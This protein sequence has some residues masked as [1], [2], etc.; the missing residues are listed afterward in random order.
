MT[1]IQQLREKRYRD[2]LKRC[3]FRSWKAANNR[4]C[5]LIEEHVYFDC[6]ETS[7]ELHALQK[8]AD[9]YMIW[10][11]NDSR[12]LAAKRVERMLA[13]LKEVK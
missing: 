5:D 7:L 1:K 11:T 13:K 3:G 10:K 6:E 2:H 12:G 9:L 4:R 8:L